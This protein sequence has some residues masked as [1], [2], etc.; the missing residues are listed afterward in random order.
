[1][2]RTCSERIESFESAQR[3]FAPFLSDCG[4]ETLIVAHL[5]ADHSVARLQPFDHGEPH[6]IELPI[7]EIVGM[8]LSE[9]SRAVVLAHNHPSG[10]AAPT[11]ADLDGTRALAMALKPLGIRVRDHLIFAGRAWDSF[12]ER[13]LL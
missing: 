11:P 5:R 9:G 3:L 1:M 8:A 2:D 13:G 6:R 4:K 12:R 10:D 7:R